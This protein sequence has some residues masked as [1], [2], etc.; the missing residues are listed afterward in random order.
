MPCMCWKIMHGAL[1]LAAVSFAPLA[2]A[3]TDRYDALANSPM[4]ENQPTPET[5]KL[6]KDELLAETAKFKAEPHCADK[7]RIAI[8]HMFDGL[9]HPARSKRCALSKAPFPIM[10]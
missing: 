3:Q 6:L 1:L 9:L 2:H 4:A 5:S 7:Q 8:C 10:R